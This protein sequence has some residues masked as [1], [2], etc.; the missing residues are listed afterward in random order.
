MTKPATP[1]LAALQATTEGR[2]SLAD[3]ITATAELGAAGEKGQAIQLYKIWIAFNPGHPQLFIAW[4]N[5]SALQSET[6]DPAGAIESLNGALANNPDF[7]P[8]YINLGGLL[9]RTG[10]V[11][12]GIQ[13][14]QTM[15]GRLAAITGPS[16]EHKLTAIKQ[17]GRVLIDN[18]RSAVAEAWLRQALEIRP[19]QRDVLEQFIAQRLV[20]CKWPVIEAWEGVDRAILMKGVSPC[21]WPPTPTT[22]CY[23]WPPPNA[24]SR[25]PSTSGP[26][27]PTPTDGPPRST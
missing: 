27:R 19:D 12:Q 18:R 24:M 11:D 13:Q 1:F 23:S 26:M 10:A 17:I 21:R 7:Y 2:A 16:I 20:Q 6:G 4:F 5:C 8:A 25:S 3:L 14:W 9:E 22:P 15:I